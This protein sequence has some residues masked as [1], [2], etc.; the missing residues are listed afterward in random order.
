[1]NT[2]VERNLSEVLNKIVRVADCDERLIKRLVPI[3]AKLYQTPPEAMQDRWTQ[4]A[5]IILDEIGEPQVD[6]ER[7]VVNIWQNTK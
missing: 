3:K 6:W 2:P 5:S 1:M 7:E 4:A